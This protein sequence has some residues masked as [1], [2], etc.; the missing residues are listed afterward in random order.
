MIVVRLIGGLGNQLFQF[1]TA[2]ALATLKNC[3]MALDV[4]GF[5]KYLL[6]RYSLH[7]FNITAQVV[8]D[9][10]LA[11]LHGGYHYR[12]ASLA[13]D[14]QVFSLPIPLYLEGYFQSEEY[15]KDCRNQIL[16]ELKVVSPLGPKNLTLVNF[17]ER[18]SE[19]VSLHVRRGDYVSNPSANA[20]HGTCGADYYRK[21]CEY[22]LSR[23]KNPT[24]VVF[25]DD[26]AWAKENLEVPGNKVFVDWND[27]SA[28]FAD[29][30]LQQLCHH[31]IIANSSFSWWGAWLGC[32][33]SKEV[34]APKNWF[35]KG[36]HV[37]H[38]V[39]PER[40]VSF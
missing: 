23:T 1:A 22:M 26:I 7:H 4:S 21:A 34:V 10:V 36:M 15:F 29:L 40:W 17:L 19:T 18:V 27:A 32:S 9:R 3:E 24:F 33:S 25:S 5:Q 16:S 14:S 39:V 37:G 6:H 31:N 11:K 30:K 12:E 2:R 28:N 8:D 38:S 13:F 35:Q 20:V